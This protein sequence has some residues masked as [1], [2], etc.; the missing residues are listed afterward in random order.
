[1][2]RIPNHFHTAEDLSRMN[3]INWDGKLFLIPEKLLK[4]F[5]PSNEV[6]SVNGDKK[7]LSEIDTDTRAGVLAYGFY[8][9]EDNNG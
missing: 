9:K 7:L 3:L 6:Y 1:M 4:I 5:D 2:I 8:C